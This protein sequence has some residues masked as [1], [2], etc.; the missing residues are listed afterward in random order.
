MTQTQEEIIAKAILEEIETAIREALASLDGA[1]SNY[2]RELYI[3]LHNK[4][5]KIAEITNLPI[6]LIRKIA[7]LIDDKIAVKIGKE[8]VI[9]DFQYIKDG[10]EKRSSRGKDRHKEKQHSEGEEKDIDEEIDEEIELE[11]EN[12]ENL[13]RLA[14]VRQKNHAKKI[15]KDMLFAMIGSRMDPK[16]R[17]GET[18]QSNVKNAQTYGRENFLTVGQ[19]LKAGVITTALFGKLE[20]SG[21][22]ENTRVSVGKVQDIIR[23]NSAG[24]FNL[25]KGIGELAKEV[26]KIPSK[27]SALLT[28]GNVNKSLGIFDSSVTQDKD[29]IK[30]E[31]TPFV[32]QVKSQ[33]RGMDF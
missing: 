23:D 3:D 13:A 21:I 5:E 16:Q 25:V 8:L 29:R 33:D 11:P 7:S 15:L 19:L 1:D 26:I 18:A 12:L 31:Y 32:Q 22:T 10:D 28:L 9:T 2:Y 4:Q 20:L 6:E 17:A 27:G 30:P 14:E 24:L